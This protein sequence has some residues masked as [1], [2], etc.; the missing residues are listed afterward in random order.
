[1]KDRNKNRKGYKR[2]K[3]GWIPENW[4]NRS[5]GESFSIIMDGTHFSP[6]TGS[7]LR[8]YITSRNIRKGYL[9][10]QNC[11]HI[12]EKAHKEIYKKCPIRIG[13]ILLTKDGASVGNACIN[14]LD[15]EF[16]LLSSVAVL[17]GKTGTLINRY[18]IQ[19]ILSGR[20]QY[21]IL[22][23]VS[24]QAITRITL[25]AIAGIKIPL[26]PLPEQKAIA[27]V[28]ECWD[29]TIQKYE[30]KI[31]KK[32]NIKRELMQKLLSGEQRLPG[33]D[34]EWEETRLGMMGTFSKGKGISRKDTVKSGLP[35]I[36]YG[37]IYTTDAFVLNEFESR[38]SHETARLSRQITKNDLLFACSGETLEDIGKSIAYMGTKVAYA[39]GDI[40][41]FS[42]SVNKAGS[43][44]LAYYLNTRG[45]S[46]LR[47]RGQGQ[48]VV[49]IYSKHLES[50]AI[51]LPKISEQRAIASVLSS[52]DSEIKA[53]DKKL[54]LLRDQK[55]YLLNNLVTG[56]IRL[57]KFCLD[58]G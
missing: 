57:P 24:G 48:S 52:A 25:T 38:I 27:S 16:S 47:R 17:D 40:V 32:K 54:A 46:E 12:S 58:V 3:V 10:L 18:A 50:I 2:T 22:S 9:D 13:Q 7:G 51:L 33:F 44:F 29:K 55:K 49:H 53:L 39:G 43:D 11:S 41:V 37:E 23:T 30:E 4:V 21:G 1:M 34:G 28:L 6:K 19:W 42:P 15:E 20:G 8:K 56:T 5:L 26:P 14:P 36:R 35:C 31:Q 45:R